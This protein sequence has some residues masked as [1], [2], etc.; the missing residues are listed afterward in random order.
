[1]RSQEAQTINAAA[2]WKLGRQS[3]KA[4]MHCSIVKFWYK[5]L[6]MGKDKLLK[7]CYE[8]HS[9]NTK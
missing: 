9:G 4:K 6:F 1:M 5:M 3:R 2:K 8:W 7:C